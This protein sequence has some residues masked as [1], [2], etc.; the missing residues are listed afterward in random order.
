MNALGDIIKSCTIC[1]LT[2]IG[3]MIAWAHETLSFLSVLFAAILGGHA[4]WRI[5]FDKGSKR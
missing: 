1:W 4:V 2:Y 3:Y 5:F